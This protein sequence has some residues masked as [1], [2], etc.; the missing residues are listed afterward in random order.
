VKGIE[1]IE[2]LTSI[3]DKMANNQFSKVLGV[4]YRLKKSKDSSNWRVKSY[5]VLIKIWMGQNFTKD[6]MV[7]NLSTIFQC[8]KL[9]KFEADYFSHAPIAQT[10]LKRYSKFKSIRSKNVYD[11]IDHL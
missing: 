7:N 10:H 8:L 1:K 4:S 6:E 9:T 5:D 2:N 3:I 11:D